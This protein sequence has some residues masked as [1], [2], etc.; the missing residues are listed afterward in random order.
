MRCGT[1][2]INGWR[3]VVPYAPYAGWRGSGVGCELGRAG[4]RGLRPLAA[5][6]RARLAPRHGAPG[7]PTPS[8]R[9]W[10]GHPRSRCRRLRPP[11]GGRPG[12]AGPRPPG[13]APRADRQRPPR[14]D[15]RP[16]PRARTGC[17]WRVR[18]PRAASSTTIRP[19]SGAKLSSR[20]S[21]TSAA[22]RGSTTI[23][24]VKWAPRSPSPT[25]IRPPARQRLGECGAGALTRRALG[26]GPMSVRSS[27]GISDHQRPDGRRQTRREV[28]P[29]RARDDH[30]LGRHAQLACVGEAAERGSGGGGIEIGARQ[31]DHGVVA[32]ALGDVGAKRGRPRAYARPRPA[33]WRLQVA[34]EAWATT[35]PTPGS[36][37]SGSASGP[38]RSA[39]TSASAGQAPRK[40]VEHQ[41]GRPAHARGRP[42]DD[43]VAGDE[44]RGGDEGRHPYRRVGRVPAEHDP[45]G[46][47]LEERRPRGGRHRHGPDR[48]AEIGQGVEQPERRLHLAPGET[49]RL[50]GFGDRGVNDRAG[51]GGEGVARGRAARQALVEV[52]RGHLRLG[53][54]R[55]ADEVRGRGEGHDGPG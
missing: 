13:R 10:A 3:V 21:A 18:A 2:A 52:D 37:T 35:S 8:A 29:D 34:L 4:P 15:R 30:A 32:R 20:Q 22:R 26:E 1:V 43:S 50:A 9:P 23:V 12:R 5:P 7:G 41:R 44:G 49:S 28:L 51:D 17:R 42:A 54:G 24:G 33:R 36:Q 39:T 47:P 16:R 45:I 11:P 38:G 31:D 40:G 27:V 53:S 6:A 14:P 25:R 19:R 55:G 48:L 46:R